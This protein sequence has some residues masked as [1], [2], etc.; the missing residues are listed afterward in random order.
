V[1]EGENLPCTT[2]DKRF[3]TIPRCIGPDK[4][5]PKAAVRKR[6]LVAWVE[7][8]GMIQEGDSVRVIIP[9][10]VIYSF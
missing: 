6:G 8:P 10:Q 9:E 2:P 3:R 4:R 1:V 5:I 7:R